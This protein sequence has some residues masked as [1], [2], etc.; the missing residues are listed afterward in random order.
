M[1]LASLTLLAAGTALLSAI[2]QPGHAAI[3]DAAQA[4]AGLRALA[5]PTL[6]IQ[7]A[8][9]VPP[10]QGFPERCRL[11]ATLNPRK[12][13]GGRDFGMGFELNLPTLWNRRFLFQGGGGL[14]GVIIPAVG[15]VSSGPTALTRGY[16][17]V[18]TDAGH[19]GQDAAFGDDSQAR[20]D[21]AYNALDKVTVEAKAILQGYYGRR[22]D[23]SYF[24]G[25]SNGGRQGLI[26][27]SRFPTYFDGVV[28]GDPGFNLAAVSV[29]QVWDTLAFSRIA[30][31]DATGRPILAGAFSPADLKLVSAAVLK[32]CDDKDG[33][34]DGM[35]N[36]FKACRYSPKPLACTGQKTD[37]CLTAEQVTALETVFDGP[38][39]SK[40]QPLYSSWAYDAGLGD[41][42]WR[43]WKL[44]DSPTAQSNSLNVVLGFDSLRRYFTTPPD[45]AFDLMKYDFDKDP[46]RTRQTSAIN[47]VKEPALPAFAAR[48]KL[49]IYQ[50]GSDPVFSLNDIVRWYEALAKGGGGDVS[51]WA[52]LFVV[53]GMVHCVGGPSTD[54]FDP[55][56]AMERW[57][58]E[59]R[60]PERMVARG[61]SFP[62]VSRPLCPYPKVARYVSGDVRDEIS[63]ACR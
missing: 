44:G 13:A 5:S 53:P 57:V 4:C 7:S 39:T 52:R 28:A 16:A 31:K 32:A 59:G 10:G 58:E 12:G 3:F 14:D 56:T 1:K 17:V 15:F 6:V 41:P 43:A 63:F 20:M 33:L 26:A 47:D 23:H 40:G 37:S 9:I 62:G 60:P 49:L 24:L 8:E 11:R 22:P 21:F 36:D 51:G 25:C 61:Q 18:S 2:P 30:P 34:A 45:P 55:L 29:S 38:K 50:G 42:G 46:A 27:A 35:I 19:Q 54:Q 48:A